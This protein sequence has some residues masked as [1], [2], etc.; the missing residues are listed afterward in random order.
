MIE[1]TNITKTFSGKQG[2]IHALKDVSLSVGKGEI[3]GVIGYSGA[4][5]STLIRCVNLLEQPDQGSVKVNDVELTTLKAG[6]LRETRSHIGM[7]FQG[8]NLLKTA[9]VYDNIAIPLKLTGLDKQA[10]KERVQKYLDIVGLAGKHDAYPSELSGG[11]KQRV[12]IARAL[13]HEPEV[14]L[15]DEATSAL[16]PDTTEAIL[17]LLLRIN[18]ELGITILLITHEMNV[19]QRICDRVA[20]M[21]NGEV[22]EEGN[23]KDIFISPQQRTTKRFVNSL[24]SHDIPDDLVDRLS[25]NG[26]VAKLSFFGESSGDP[27]LALVTKKYNIYPNILSGSITRIKEEAFGQ[28]LVHFK[29]EQAEINDAFQFLQDQQVHVEGVTFDGENQRVS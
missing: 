12:A 6:K 4:G 11:Q 27:A 15:S 16:D 8:F 9:T 13:S 2:D 29:G 5:K 26:Q 24:F 7:I 25:E 14:L 18:K 28:L 1:L 17:D 19:I 10:V 22:I 3:Y 21:E 23:T 20:V